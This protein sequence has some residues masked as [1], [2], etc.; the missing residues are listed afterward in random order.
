MPHCNR[1]K[2]T[3]RKRAVHRIHHSAWAG[4]TAL[5]PL[6]GLSQDDSPAIASSRRLRL[7]YGKPSEL[8]GILEFN[9][10]HWSPM[11]KPRSSTD[12]LDPVA[13]DRLLV[14]ESLDG[15]QPQIAGVSA[16]FL[17]DHGVAEIGGTRIVRPGLR[18]Q[19]VVCFAFFARI[20]S[21][22]EL[23]DRVVFCCAQRENAASIGG[24]LRSGFRRLDG[25]RNESLVRRLCKLRDTPVKGIEFFGL[26]RETLIQN[27]K[28]FDRLGS[29]LLL[30]D[31]YSS[32]VA[33]E[34]APRFG[35]LSW[36]VS[37]SLPQR[38]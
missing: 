27:A 9:R 13:G 7:R 35:R 4:S 2:A 23:A 8:S 21:D 1:Y 30:F 38:S 6:A 32:P 5:P 24:I 11:N 29:R 18:L 20:A 31:C 22:P 3:G 16:I 19:V 34:L 26:C 10:R 37:L 15:S 17:P 14:I 33:G 36:P 28:H 12:I 25:E